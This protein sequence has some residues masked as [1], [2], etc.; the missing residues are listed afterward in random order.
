MKE[1]NYDNLCIDCGARNTQVTFLETSQM[2][3]ISSQKKNLVIRLKY[4][5]ESEM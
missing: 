4:H 1:F 3:I 5:C 2:K